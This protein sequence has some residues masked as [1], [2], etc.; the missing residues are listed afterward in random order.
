[1]IDD[2]YAAKLFRLH[3]V[4]D[5]WLMN[6]AAH[7]S[8]CE[9]VAELIRSPQCADASR[10]VRGGL[11]CSGPPKE[12]RIRARIGR[13]PST[14]AP[15]RR[16]PSHSRIATL[17]CPSADGR[18]SGLVWRRYGLRAVR[19]PAFALASGVFKRPDSTIDV[20]LRLACGPVSPGRGTLAFMMRFLE[21]DG[22]VCRDSTIAGPGVSLSVSRSRSSSRTA[23]AI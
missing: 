13:L 22:L 23:E 11:V 6:V 3:S 15:H 16:P 21:S 14:W 9:Q 17:Q 8:A 18:F 1:M 4:M 7:E 19:S 2:G 5:V 10:R 20:Q 12:A